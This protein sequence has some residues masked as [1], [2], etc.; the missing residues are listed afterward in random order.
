M[1]VHGNGFFRVNVRSRKEI[2]INETMEMPV[3][4]TLASLRLFLRKTFPYLPGYFKFETEDKVKIEQSLE[5]RV[6][7][8]TLGPTVYLYPFIP[9]YPKGQDPESL[10]ERQ[11]SAL[12]GN[13]GDMSTKRRGK[14]K[15]DPIESERSLNSRSGSRQARRGSPS[16]GSSQDAGDDFF[17]G[18]MYEDEGFVPMAVREKVMREW[19]ENLI[20]SM[21]TTEIPITVDQSTS[22]ATGLS[23]ISPDFIAVLRKSGIES[24]A[25]KLDMN[26]FRSISA[27]EI[28][29]GSTPSVSFDDNKEFQRFAMKQTLMGL[30][31]S[32]VLKLQMLSRRRQAYQKVSRVRAEKA[33]DA[34]RRALLEAVEQADK[35]GSSDIP[36]S[37][38]PSNGGTEL[39][40]S[41]AVVAT[42]APVVSYVLGEDVMARLGSD[43]DLLPARIVAVNGDGSYDLSFYH[44]EIGYHIPGVDLVSNSG[45]IAVPKSANQPLPEYEVPYSERR[46][47]VQNND[48]PSQGENQ[49]LQSDATTFSEKPNKKSLKKG[50]SR[51]LLSI[52]KSVRDLEMSAAEGFVGEFTHS[53][54]IDKMKM[55][56]HGRTS[57]A[58]IVVSIDSLD[59][60][61][62][63]TSK[64]AEKK[65]NAESDKS[66]EMAEMQRIERDEA[67]K[68]RLEEEEADADAKQRETEQAAA[69]A[70]AAFKTHPARPV[71]PQSVAKDTAALVINGAL[72]RQARPSSASADMTIMASGI[73]QQAI[74]QG[75]QR[76]SSPSPSG[77]RSDASDEG[78]LETSH[79]GKQDEVLEQD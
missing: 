45:K 54:T 55:D 24:V 6:L 65:Q 49:L 47:R 71:T 36:L 30:V 43:L 34:E 31:D 25:N 37:A 74:I 15:L 78:V 42:N 58:R 18:T 11:K 13:G 23:G 14:A 22:E 29:D 59:V 12:G 73:A 41:Q 27:L 16:F 35:L 5:K 8:H 79:A 64:S 51:L 70:A 69:E 39:L 17:N 2:C 28:R 72:S 9:K 46:E 62:M 52:E 60:S 1:H 66:R 10:M 32:Q 56:I 4:V 57:K 33:A 63:K 61:H 3:G 53:P 44:G 75:L 20:A 26:E 7:A 67:R 76:Q 21:T 50:K 19:D 68:K 38:G 77:K 48:N 40:S